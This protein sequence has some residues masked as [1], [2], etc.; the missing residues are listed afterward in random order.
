M[1]LFIVLV[2]LRF[3]FLVGAFEAQRLTVCDE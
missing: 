2:F 1:S 3:G